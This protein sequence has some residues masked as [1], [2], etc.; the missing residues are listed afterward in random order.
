[1]R[2]YPQRVISIGSGTSSDFPER[3]RQIFSPDGLLSKAE[4][5]EFRPEQLQM[6]KAVAAAVRCGTKNQ[7]FEVWL[8]CGWRAGQGCGDL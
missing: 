8:V 7:D 1:L 3:I 5:F 4:N 6:V 2:A